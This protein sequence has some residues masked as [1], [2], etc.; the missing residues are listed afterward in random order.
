MSGCTRGCTKS[1][2]RSP[3]QETA[4]W[5]SP[6]AMT[7]WFYRNPK[8]RLYFKNNILNN[9]AYYYY[10]YK[11]N[12]TY[13]KTTTHS[14]HREAVLSGPTLRPSSP[15]FCSTSYPSTSRG[16]LQ[17]FVLLLPGSPPEVCLVNWRPSPP[18]GGGVVSRQ[19]GSQPAALGDGPS[20]PR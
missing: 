2:S 13:P 10:Y 19:D 6:P 1:F 15:A 7:D 3:A 20:W 8:E 11:N 14:P 12:I 16:A 4:R 18:S 9:I 5:W 17:L